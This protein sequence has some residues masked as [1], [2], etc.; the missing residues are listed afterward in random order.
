MRSFRA[1]GRSGAVGFIAAMLLALGSG[2]ASAQSGECMV[3]LHNN[4]VCPPAKT[5]CLM[6]KH[7]GAIKCSPPDG[8]VIADRYGVA[9]CGTG[10][11][12][13]DMRGDAFCSRQSGGAAAKSQ[14]GDAVCTGG[15]DKAQ[16]AM[17]TTLKR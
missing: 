14:Y 3:D 6:E 13:L 15:C 11:C 1:M 9:Q 16:A 2:L 12:V 17:C 7:G 5:I 8:G 4:T 10:R